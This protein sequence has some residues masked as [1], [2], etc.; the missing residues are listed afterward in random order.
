MN[1][2]SMQREQLTCMMGV[3]PNP[4][5]TRNSGSPPSPPFASHTCWQFVWSGLSLLIAYLP[6]EKVLYTADMNIVNA[7][8]AQLATVRA[9]AQVADQLKLDYNKATYRAEERR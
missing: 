8:P 9:A 6:A 2:R 1:V 4:F 3:G 7:N 5:I